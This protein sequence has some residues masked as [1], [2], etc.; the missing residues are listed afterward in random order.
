MA[1]ATGHHLFLCRVA[2]GDPSLKNVG[3]KGREARLRRARGD[4][5]LDRDRTTVQIEM[6]LDKNLVFASKA[7]GG[8]SERAPT[9]VKNVAL[10]AVYRSS[11]SSTRIWSPR[12]VTGIGTVASYSST[13][14]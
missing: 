11:E 3:E 6:N 4:W 13:V 1:E 7:S 5:P 12:T 8:S 2:S 9:S 10:L 14:T